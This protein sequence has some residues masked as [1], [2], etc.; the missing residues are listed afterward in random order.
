MVLRNPYR[1]V[2]EASDR[3]GQRLGELVLEPDFAPAAE[4]SHWEGVRRGLPARAHHGPGVVEP[5]FDDALGPPY[6]EGFRVRL[7]DTDSQHTP[8][9]LPW[10][11]FQPAVEAAA[12]RLV[13]DGRL[14]DGESFVYRV[15]AFPIPGAK[16]PSAPAVI[17]E[18]PAPLALEPVPLAP[19]QLGAT[20]LGQNAWNPAD[21]P[22]FVRPGVLAG[23]TELARAAGE[24]ETGGILIGHLCRDPHSAEIHAEITAQIPARRAEAGHAH[25]SFTPETWSA[26]SDA[27]ALRRRNE[28]WLGWWH[29][30]PFFCRRCD[31]A[32]R[33]LCALSRPFFSRDDCEL[34][35]AVFDA[36][37][38]V[39]L[40][41][42]DLGE[43]MLRYD[44]FG[45]RQ[46]I[47]AARGCYRLAD[48]ATSIAV[49][50]AQTV[51]TPPARALSVKEVPH[52][53]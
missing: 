9:L 53:H 25:L 16:R 12:S 48:E 40:L 41:L 49:P 13:Q 46:G 39:A 38:S 51:T 20:R 4:W 37:F 50:Q 8:P 22:I 14:Q 42:S 1:Y 15:C 31:P 30:H 6:L 10:R 17:D 19:R 21:Y 26:V 28:V 18:P 29:S 45:W 3:E 52:E 32:R 33:R 34:H 5:V 24:R 11:Y 47:I 44:W 36:A 2:A 23:A 43:A 27:L 35:R 7:D